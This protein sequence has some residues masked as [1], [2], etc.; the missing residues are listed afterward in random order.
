MEKPRISFGP[1]FLEAFFVVLGV[2][3]AL[4][5]NE[6]RQDRAESE[7]TAIAE[8]SLRDEITFNQAMLRSSLDY[9]IALM[10]SLRTHSVRN[11]Q[12]GSTAPPSISIFGKG[13][14]H[15]TDL[16]TISWSLALSTDALSNIPYERALAFSK[17]YAQYEGYTKQTNNVADLLYSDLY[18]DGYLGVLDNF[19]N[20]NIILGTFAYTECELL[21]TVENSLSEIGGLELAAEQMAPPYC[22]YIPKR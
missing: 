4:A 3:L 22:S 8:E 5:A 15:P 6:W 14:V 10:D 11:R 7:R 18:N 20:L 2:V 16:V 12:T 13:F 1:I 19:E 21:T 17:I 9:H